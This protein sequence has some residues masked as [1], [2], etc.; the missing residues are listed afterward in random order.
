MNRDFNRLVQDLRD[1]HCSREAV[2]IRS[3]LFDELRIGPRKDDDIISIAL[4]SN[5]NE[6]LENVNKVRSAIRQMTSWRMKASDFV[7]EQIKSRI[8]NS[9]T[10]LKINSVID[11]EDL[12]EV[13]IL[14][15]SE[16]N[17]VYDH[18]DVRNSN[19]LIEKSNL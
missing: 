3:W 13:E 11:F 17:S 12:G 10:K 4:V 1:K 6:L 2:T 7:I 18:V 19:R 9:R 8:K 14:E 5:N 15:I 16:I